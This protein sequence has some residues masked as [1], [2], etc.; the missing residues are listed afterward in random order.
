MSRGS[1]DMNYDAI[2]AW[3]ALVAAIIAVLAIWAESRRQRFAMGVELLLRL[4]EQ[5]HTERMLANKK[6]IACAFL[7]NDC[8]QVPNEMIEII[9][10]YDEVGFFVRR[11]GLDKK[12][13]YTFFFSYM[14]RFWYVARDYVDQERRQDPTLWNDYEK[15]YR[16]LHKIELAERHKL[17]VSLELQEDELRQY[18]A[19]DAEL[20]V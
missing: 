8:S 6:R 10:F 18:F 16:D 4:D 11:G 15:L 1:K 3:A 19:E 5:F 13:V 14:F 17:K 20:E 9:D 7:A 2:T 12:A